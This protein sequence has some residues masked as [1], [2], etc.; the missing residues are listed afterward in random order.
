MFGFA[1]TKVD[2]EWIGFVKLILVKIEL[3]VKWF[4]FDQI[5][6][7]SWNLNVECQNQI[8]KKKTA[9]NHSFKLESI[10]KEKSIFI[11]KTYKNV[12]I[13]STRL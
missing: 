4:M 11:G 13:D 6:Q 1:V 7:V 3:L 9:T 10:Q 5:L 12:K 8:W 2:F